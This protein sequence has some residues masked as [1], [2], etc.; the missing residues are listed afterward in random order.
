VK[1]LEMPQPGGMMGDM[2]TFASFR[3]TVMMEHWK[4]VR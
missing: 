1:A 4:A 3:T 2:V